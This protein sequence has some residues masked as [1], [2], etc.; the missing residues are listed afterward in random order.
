[1]LVIT[2]A[3]LAHS[4]SWLVGERMTFNDGYVLYT[5]PV[6]NF[7]E[8]ITN[9]GGEHE[10]TAGALLDVNRVDLTRLSFQARLVEAVSPY[11]AVIIDGECEDLP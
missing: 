3:R 9:P 8:V 7:Y 1:M 4:E 10:L 5:M 6:G 11:E 2:L